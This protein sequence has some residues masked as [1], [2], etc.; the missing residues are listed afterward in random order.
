MGS[1]RKC[2]GLHS[3]KAAIAALGLKL[4]TPSVLTAL[5]VDKGRTEKEVDC[6]ARRR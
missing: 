4:D 2:H 5:S 6:G 1:A 3:R